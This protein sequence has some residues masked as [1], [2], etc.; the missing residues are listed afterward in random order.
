MKNVM[1][2]LIFVITIIFLLST[3]MPANADDNCGSY[4]RYVLR[5]MHVYHANFETNIESITEK[6]KKRYGQEGINKK[7]KLFQEVSSIIIDPTNQEEIKL[8]IVS[9]TANKNYLQR[10][11]L[12]LAESIRGSFGYEED[13]KE[14]LDDAFKLGA[15]GEKQKEIQDDIFTYSSAIGRFISTREIGDQYVLSVKDGKGILE[16]KPFN[17]V[18]KIRLIE[19]ADLRINKII[20]YIKETERIFEKLPAELNGQISNIKKQGLDPK[21]TTKVIDELEN[22]FYEKKV[23]MKEKL[24]MLKRKKKEEEYYKNSILKT[25]TFQ[26]IKPERLVFENPEIIRRTISS[27]IVKDR[28]LIEKMPDEMLSILMG[29]IMSSV[30][31]RQPG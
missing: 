1:K 17:K 8:N 10:E 2:T 4:D 9:M 24:K 11:I 19:N 12:R 13:D 29:N 16:Y 27:Y 15:K 7:G 14:F 23:L 31:Y 21:E 25:Y 6:L 3:S 20:D 28:C 26:K 5:F 18:E 30:E 22:Q